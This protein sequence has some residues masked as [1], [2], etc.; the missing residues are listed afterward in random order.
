MPCLRQ[1]HDVGPF[2]SELDLFSKL[3]MGDTWS[4]AK[5]TDCYLYLWKSKKLSIP[6][7]WKDT[8]EQFT[9]EL[10]MVPCINT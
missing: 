1:K 7:E 9:E 10:K 6:K 5:L 3:E 4:D 8:M 2:Q